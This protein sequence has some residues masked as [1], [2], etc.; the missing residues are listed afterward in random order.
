MRAEPDVGQAKLLRIVFG[1]TF[2]K[3]SPYFRG[4]FDVDC[5]INSELVSSNM[6]EYLTDLNQVLNNFCLEIEIDLQE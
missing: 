6:G 2:H 5:F 1:P 4:Q 3:L